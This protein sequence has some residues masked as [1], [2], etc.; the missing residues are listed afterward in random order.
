MPAHKNQ[1]KM[2]HTKGQWK[3]DPDT[4]N[5]MSGKIT[6]A[7]PHG[8]AGKHIDVKDEHEANAKLITAAPEL[9]EACQIIARHRALLVGKLTRKEN[10]ILQ[11][12]IKKAT[13]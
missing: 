13:E 12:A 9:L 3:I 8:S 6:V 2:K 10:D 11:S 4:G 5:V 1:S 7:V